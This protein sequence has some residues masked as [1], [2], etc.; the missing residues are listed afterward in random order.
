MLLARLAV[1]AAGGVGWCCWCW[2][3]CTPAF[4]IG[5]EMV[6]IL[7][8]QAW[9]EQLIHYMLWTSLFIYFVHPQHP[10]VSHI[11]KVCYAKIV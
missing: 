2:S 11:A 10:Q 1:V 5:S 4:D 9:K 3:Q 7:E 6:I 8:D